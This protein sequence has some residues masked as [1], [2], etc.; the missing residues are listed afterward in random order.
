ME[1]LKREIEGIKMEIKMKEENWEKERE[2]IRGKI[3]R[4]EK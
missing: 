2:M 3:E 1:G 4:L